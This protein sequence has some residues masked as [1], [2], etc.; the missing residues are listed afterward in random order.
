M[1][2]MKKVKP[3]LLGSRTTL[4]SNFGAR[5]SQKKVTTLKQ[6]KIK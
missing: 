3:P 6:P 4:K 2:K 5:T 1:S